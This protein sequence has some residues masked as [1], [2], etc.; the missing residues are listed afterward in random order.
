MFV[1]FINESNLVVFRVKE[2]SLVGIEETGRRRVGLIV[3]LWQIVLLV[4]GGCG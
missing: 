3:F 2:R 4:D 1:E